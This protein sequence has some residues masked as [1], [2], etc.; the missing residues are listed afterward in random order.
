MVDIVD[1]KENRH[2]TID[3]PWLLSADPNPTRSA[4]PVGAVLLRL[5]GNAPD[6][7]RKA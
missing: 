6:K 2:I 3:E 1:L 7:K 4:T 5:A